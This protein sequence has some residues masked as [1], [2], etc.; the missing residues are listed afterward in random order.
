MSRTALVALH[1]AE[2]AIPKR[3]LTRQIKMLCRNVQEYVKA[4]ATLSPHLNL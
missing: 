4:I 1:Q 2:Q 3:N